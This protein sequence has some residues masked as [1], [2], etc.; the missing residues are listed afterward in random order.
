MPRPFRLRPI[1]MVRHMTAYL[2]PIQL[3][4]PARARTL[5]GQA[6]RLEPAIHT[7]LTD[8]EPPSR[9]GLAASIA[10]KRHNPLAQIC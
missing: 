7:R 2:L 1:G 4:G 6:A 8:L 9:V 5:V 10:N 3:A